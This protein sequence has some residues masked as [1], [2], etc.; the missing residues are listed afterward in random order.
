MT[1]LIGHIDC[2]AFRYSPD[3]RPCLYHM[4][5]K[6]HRGVGAGRRDRRRGEGGGGENKEEEGERG[7]RNYSLLKK[8]GGLC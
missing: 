2:V 1:F 5:L 8:R 4:G 3:S 7:R 6:G